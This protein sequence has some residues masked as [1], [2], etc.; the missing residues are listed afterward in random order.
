MLAKLNHEG[1]PV[2]QA[3]AVIQT[4]AQGLGMTITGSVNHHTSGC[5]ISEA[6]IAA[7]LQ[8][9][10]AVKEGKSKFIFLFYLS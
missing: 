9:V 10:G 1:V 2:K 3:N 5:C 4:V 6:G 8:F 7:E